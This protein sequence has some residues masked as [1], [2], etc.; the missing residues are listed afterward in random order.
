[1]QGDRGATWSFE[2]APP[3][4]THDFQTDIPRLNRFSLQP[5]VFYEGGY[6]ETKNPSIS[7]ES[8]SLQSAG[9]GIRI[10]TGDVFALQYDYGHQLDD[11]GFNDNESGR[12]HI[13]LTAS[14]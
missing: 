9:V 5:V 6:L 7:E 14:F 13:R 8:R 2:L 10:N 11:D 3:A 4:W 1:M 12:H